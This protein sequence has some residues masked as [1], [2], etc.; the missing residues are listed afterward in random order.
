[1]YPSFNARALGLRLS[2]RAT[3]EL[4][5]A[6][7]FAG[8]DFLVREKKM[9]RDDA[10]VLCSAAC[11]FHVTQTVDQTKGIHGLLLKSIVP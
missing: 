9:D 11:D 5:A 8:V 7:G 2:A 3:I 1:M 10:Y 6:T 4:A